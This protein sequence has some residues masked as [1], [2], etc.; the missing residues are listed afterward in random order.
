MK[1]IVLAASMAFALSATLAQDKPLSADEIRALVTGKTMDVENQGLSAA[2]YFE[3]GGSGSAR[4]TS[5][6]GSINVSLK[7]QVND[8]GLFCTHV[9]RA[10]SEETCTSV[11]KAQDGAY[12]RVKDGKVVSTFKMR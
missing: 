1:K 4:L 2:L 11:H 12:T 3:A 7:W 9:L 10:G 6:R 5:P 8:N